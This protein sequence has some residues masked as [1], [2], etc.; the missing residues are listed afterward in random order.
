MQDIKKKFQEFLSQIKEHFDVNKNISINT[1]QKIV[2][3]DQLSNLINSGIPLTNSLKI[4]S[5]QTKNKSIKALITDTLEQMNKWTSLWDAFTRYKKIFNNFDL[6]ILQMWE[7][8]GKIWE[9][10]DIIKEKEEKNKELK[11]K[12]IGALIY[13]MVIITLSLA[14]IGVFMIYVIP[15]IKK[16]YKD[17]KVNLPDLTQNVIN[18][19]EFMQENITYIILSIVVFIICIIIFKTNKRTKIYWDRFV[20]K[21]PLFGGLIQ[22]KILALFASSMG[23]LLSSGIIINES[24]KISSSALEN[25]FY[26]KELHRVLKEVSKWVELSELMWVNEIT[27]WKENKYF[28]IALSSVV[29]IWEQTGKM[30]HLLTKLSL[31]FNKEIDDIVKNIQTAIEPIVIVWV[32]AI[33]GTL[34]MAIMLP[35]F[36]MV[37]VI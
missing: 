3:L 13:P 25:D 5:Y 26:E 30:P 33:I 24:I 29:K 11:G 1:K 27:L 35:F 2:F 9:S 16:M 23:T 36:N 7:V 6:A 15:K 22:K 31:Q 12:I 28:P 37:N 10:I 14:M 19:S 17:A 18:I 4:M 20:L 21:I 34:I 8:T 32:G